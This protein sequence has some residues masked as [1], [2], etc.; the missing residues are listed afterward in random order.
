MTAHSNVRRFLAFLVKPAIL[1]LF[2]FATVALGATDEPPIDPS[3]DFSPMLF[4]FA[5]I[6]FCLVLFLVGAGIVVVATVAISA[7]ILTALG[8]VSSAAFIG[9]LRQR[10]SSGFR[11]LHYQLFAV[12]ALPAGVGALWLGS[13]FFTTHLRHRDIFAI[14][15]IAGICG[16]LLL[17]F[18]FDRLASIAYRRFVSPSIPNATGNA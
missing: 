3:D 11:A 2:L 8:I 5:L 4:A 9:I 14:G 17:A 18:A 7:A 1:L 16:G 12:A 15:S 6:G 13:H 10:F